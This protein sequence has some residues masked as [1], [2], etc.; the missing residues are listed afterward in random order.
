[1][2]MH[3]EMCRDPCF[4]CSKF[5]RPDSPMPP[6]SSSPLYQAYGV[7]V[8]FH[9]PAKPPPRK[10]PRPPV[11]RPSAPGAS[12]P[13]PLGNPYSGGGW[14]TVRGQDP[15]RRHAKLGLPPCRDSGDRGDDRVAR[16]QGRREE[17]PSTYLCSQLVGDAFESMGVLK[18]EAP[19]GMQWLWVLPGAF[20][21][22]GAVERALDRG[23]SLGEEVSA[24]V[25]WCGA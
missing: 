23:V 25:V 4:R 20:G 22:G 24:R 10:A 21:Q 9:P 13:M 18:K 11:V 5:S 16:C 3:R 6:T 17:L 2:K 15:S 1:M 8:P 14:G 7:I 12:T 19:R